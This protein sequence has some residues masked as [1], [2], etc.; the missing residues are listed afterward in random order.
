MAT[1]ATK[2]LISTGKINLLRGASAESDDDLPA[3]ALAGETATWTD[4]VEDWRAFL[5]A[6]RAAKTVVAYL[7]RLA[8]LRRWAEGQGIGVCAFRGRHLTKYLAGRVEAGISPTTRRHDAVVAKMFFAWA[9][10]E[11]YL[12]GN[13]LADYKVA[14]A[15]KPYVRMPT[16][17]EIRRLLKAL[18]ERWSIKTNPNARFM[19][20]AARQF[21]L[22]RN[23][24]I[25]SGLIETAMR[26]GEMLSLRLDDFDPVKCQV[27]VRVAKGKEPRLVPISAAWIEIVQAYLKKRPACGSEYLFVTAFGTKID[28]SNFSGDFRGY[29]AYAGLSGFCLHGLR[30]YAITELAKTNVWA[31]SQIAGHKDLKTTM[32]YL[33]SSMEHVRQ[34]HADAAPLSRLLTNTRSEKA[35]RKKLI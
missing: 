21:Y 1:S 23:R 7:D 33:H 15:P 25:V 19:P 24:A 14:K 28:A 32:T 3:P 29:L 30:H 18:D 35:R 11:D 27:A 2:A 5:V 13:P 26:A 9:A 12:P 20:P 16:D 10:K 6:G 22:R 17:D 4:L 31:A 34:T 8:G